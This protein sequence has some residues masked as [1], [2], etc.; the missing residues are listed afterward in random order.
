LIVETMLHTFEGDQSEAMAKSAR[1]ASLPLP[2]VGPALRA[3]VEQARRAV[4]ALARA[5]AHSSEAKDA[6]LLT[7]A[8]RENPLLHWPMRYAAAVVHIDAG[9]PARARKLIDSA[10]EWPEG[11]VFRSFQAELAAHA[12]PPA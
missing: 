3:R 10:P 5:F 6:E 4:A 11:S 9:Q 12:S 7:S 1:L 2:D 8:A